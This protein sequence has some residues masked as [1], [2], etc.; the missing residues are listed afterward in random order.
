MKKLLLALSILALASCGCTSQQEDVQNLQ[1]HFS[2]VFPIPN[3]QTEHICIDTANQVFY[4]EVGVD[5]VI[6]SKI[7]ITK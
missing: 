5:G 3:S 2:V 6:T 1:K 4:I 7:R